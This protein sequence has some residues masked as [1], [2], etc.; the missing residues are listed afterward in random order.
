MTNRGD[1]GVIVCGHVGIGTTTLI[2]M[3]H[4]GVEAEIIVIDSEQEESKKEFEFRS[5]IPIEIIQL[6]ELSIG[7][8]DREPR[9]YGKQTKFKNSYLN[10]KKKYKT[11]RRNDRVIK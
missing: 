10:Y 11:L 5:K 4:I 2:G 8:F 1:I 3:M 6:P 9:F 7:F